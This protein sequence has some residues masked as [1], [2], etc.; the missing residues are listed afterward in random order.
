MVFWRMWFTEHLPT[1]QAQQNWTYD[2]RPFGAAN[3]LLV[4]DES[5]QLGSRLLDFLDQVIISCD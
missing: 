4:S 2:E 3:L 5:T 1:L